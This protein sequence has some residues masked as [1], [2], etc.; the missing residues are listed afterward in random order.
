MSTH[1]ITV[2]GGSVRQRTNPPA[3]PERAGQLAVL[4]A[5]FDES[6]AGN[7][8][9]GIVGGPVGCG[10][11]ELLTALSE[12]VA[13]SGAHVLMATASRV[14][15]AVPFGLL[16]HLLHGAGIAPDLTDRI[17]SWVREAQ[18]AP[19]RGGLDDGFA[20]DVAPAAFHGMCMTLL[21]LVERTPGPLFIGIDDA[22]FADLASLRCLSFVVRRLRSARLLVVLNESLHSRWPAT[23]SQAELPAEP[24]A[25]HLRLPL[26]SRQGV[27]DMLA[28]QLGSAVA[29]ALAAEACEVSGGNPMLLRGLIEDNRSA[30]TARGPVFRVGAGFSKALIGCVYRYEP[31]VRQVARRLAMLDEAPPVHVLAKLAG[32]DTD[33]T[34]QVLDLLRE[35]GLL[36]GG[37]LRHPQAAAALLGGMTAGERFALHTHTANELF[38]NGSSVV[39]VARH[40]LAADRLDSQCAIPVLHE[41]AEQA[42]VDGEG[43]FA[44]DCLRLAHE[45]DD[46]DRRRA[47]SV[48]MLIRATW[49]SSPYAAYRR[50][51]ALADD[52]SAGLLSGPRVT[53][54][55]DAHLWFGHPDEAGGL[56]EREEHEQPVAE[57]PL[58]ISHLDA[59]RLWLRALYPGWPGGRSG[60]EDDASADVSGHRSGG[61]DAWALGVSPELGAKRRAAAMLSANMTSGPDAAA[62][63]EAQETLRNYAL[64]DDTLSALLVAV[65]TLVYA[66]RL[67]EAR[68]WSDRLV[69]EAD[70]QSAPLWEALFR[71]VRAEVLLRK[72]HPRQAEQ[73]VEE[74]LALLPARNWGIALALPLS[75]ALQANALTGNESEA[76]EEAQAALP[77]ATFETPLAIRLLRA[78]GHKSMANGQA[79]AAL[80]DFLAMGEIAARCGT[81]N[82]AVAPWRSGAAMACV[83]LG[84]LDRARALV[85]E[86]LRICGARPSRVT[87]GGLRVL[88]ACSTGGDVLRFLGRAAEQLE[89]CDAPVELSF[90]LHDLGWALQ[91]QGQY[92]KGRLMLRRARLMAEECGVQISARPTAAGSTGTDQ[93][94]SPAEPAP[95]GTE[96]R[97]R[98]LSD[99]ELR[100][101]Y[102]A[103]ESHSNRQIANQLFVTVS[104]VEQHLT[105]IYRKLGIKRRT[106]LV[107]VM[108]GAGR[109]DTPRATAC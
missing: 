97:L 16:A 20:D 46:D 58:T 48:A 83:R 72:G 31:E 22:Q 102:L 1:A 76:V 55:I 87:A 63:A 85:T 103:V 43:Q 18:A 93:G 38:K 96:G 74:A 52:A 64:S 105:R 15:Q 73:Q 4:H 88:A 107:E 7:S 82:P 90:V 92:S 89:D 49:R 36:S 6:L 12:S 45:H 50:V 29:R 35:T 65:H 41:A 86:E 53:A 37:L 95:G 101:V 75:T 60:H 8:R 39:T 109:P 26:F 11:T 19:A 79:A 30:V 68:E 100:V 17:A 81:D 34:A 104:T 25:R 78:R 2:E 108:H 40:L 21:D 33:R 106:D 61:A 77:A 80:D 47:A 70:R 51:P 23:L 28:E 94:A 59:S 67:G 54:A 91:E 10:K 69:A 3:V 57:D 5:L 44:L 98:T 66:E 62:V 27:E 71:S 32:L 14:E 24:V 99:A 42:L 84:D 9:V 56:I 13:E